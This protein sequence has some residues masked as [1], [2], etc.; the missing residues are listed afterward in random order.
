MTRFSTLL[1]TLVI[2]FAGACITPVEVDFAEAEQELVVYAHFGV[3]ESMKVYLT[4]T[5]D[6]LK[7][8]QSFKPIEDATIKVYQDGELVSQV[9]RSGEP[10]K[11]LEHVA[12]YNTGIHA[13]GGSRY[14]IEVMAEGYKNARSVEVAPHHKATIRG[15]ES[16]ESNDENDLYRL[17]FSDDDS[18]DNYYQLIVKALEYDI[19]D[20]LISEEIVN[21]ELIRSVAFTHFDNNTRAWTAIYPEYAGFLFTG[22]Q[23]EGDLKELF[24]EIPSEERTVNETHDYAYKVELHSVSNAYF[25][26]HESLQAQLSDNNVL[27]E[28]TRIYNN[29]EGG[30]GN[31]SA[32]NAAVTEVSSLRVGE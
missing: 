26:Y 32:Y 2:L 29:I 3:D 12:L 22:V 23:G 10:D 14:Q 30:F 31:F 7:P 24:I 6:P 8:N 15:F 4:H 21:Y 5:R 16:L 19:L 13:I 25:L 28:P 17:L 11:D 9:N 20:S 27:T 18:E 1:G